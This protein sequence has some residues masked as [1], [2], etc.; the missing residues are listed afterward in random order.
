MA[1]GKGGVRQELIGLKRQLSRL[2]KVRWQCGLQGGGLVW[3][4]VVVEN[5]SLH[6][7]LLPCVYAQLSGDSAAR[8]S[9]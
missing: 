4:G 2:S 5:I 6:S 8:H 3:H 1:A 7:L 9:R